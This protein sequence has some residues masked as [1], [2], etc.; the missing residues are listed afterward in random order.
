ML[1]PGDGDFG[2][3]RWS[4]P[5]EAQARARG[6]RVIVPIRAG[7]GHSDP[8]PPDVPQVPQATLHVFRAGS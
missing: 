2:L 6:L 1:T 4:A 5:A 7:Y 3:V 8:L